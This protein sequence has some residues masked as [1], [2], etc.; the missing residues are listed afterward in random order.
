RVWGR[1]L[2]NKAQLKIIRHA[3][4]PNETEE[5]V[6]VPLTSNFSRPV[7]VKLENGRRTETA[8]VPPPSVVETESAPASPT[9]STDQVLSKLRSVAVAESGG[10][11]RGI[12]GDVAGP[13]KRSN[14]RR[15]LDLRSNPGD[16]TIYQNKVEGFIQNTVNMTTQAVVSA[17]R[18]S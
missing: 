9:A 14:P 16:R 7:T 5:L 4:T 2:G 13:G 15:N 8:Y 18:R 1:P 12:S 17:D 3:G 10:I 6:T 11:D